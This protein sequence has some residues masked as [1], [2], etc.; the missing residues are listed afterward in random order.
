MWIE[1]LAV[2]L[3]LLGNYLV[4]R[5]KVEGFVIWIIANLLWVYIGIVSKLWGMTTLFIAYS[6][7]NVYAVYYWRKKKK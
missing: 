6:L 5:K 4:A 2:P 1:W 3:S 7:I